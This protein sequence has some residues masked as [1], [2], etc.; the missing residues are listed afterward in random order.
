MNNFYIRS[1][2]KYCVV[3]NEK[4]YVQSLFWMQYL[5]DTKK[6]S[7][8]EVISTFNE[9]VAMSSSKNEESYEYN[10][11]IFSK[12]SNSIKKA[13][14]TNAKYS[15]Q[16]IALNFEKFKTFHEKMKILDK[17]AKKYLSEY[18]NLTNEE[19]KDYF[20]Y[21]RWLAHFSTSFEPEPY[22]PFGLKDI[23]EDNRRRALGITFTQEEIDKI[24]AKNKRAEKVF[25]KQK[26]INNYHME[27]QTFYT[28]YDF[29]HYLQNWKSILDNN[30]MP[31]QIENADETS[32]FDENNAYAI[33][34]KNEAYKT[35]VFLSNSDLTDNIGGAKLFETL[36]QAVK[37]GI[38]GAI[39]KVNVK[40]EEVVSNSYNVDVTPLEKVKASKEK[41]YLESLMS[42]EEEM[43]FLAKKLLNMCDKENKVLKSELE[44]LLL[45]EKV[46]V[47]KPSQKHKI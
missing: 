29:K 32:K 21:N 6:V 10:F 20:K 42:H 5:I 31:K 47:D 35:G 28:S 22:K 19:F 27:N 46:I 2:D 17:E 33:F 12:H 14:Y 7:N 13:H 3:K 45:K 40:L 41:K 34:L 18:E 11:L 23:I 1:N 43:N 9:L 4:F 39:V 36:E 8:Q 30:G 16:D 24:T 44:K 15:L 25:E 26:F 38:H 37:S